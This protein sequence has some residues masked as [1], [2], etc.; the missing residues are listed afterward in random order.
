M[1]GKE[2]GG[3]KKVIHRMEFNPPH[4][5]DDEHDE[6]KEEERYRGKE[7]D[8]SGQWSRLQLLRHDHG[9]LIPRQQ[10]LVGPTQVPTASGLGFGGWGNLILG[11]VYVLEVGLHVQGEVLHLGY[12]VAAKAVAPF[13]QSLRVVADLQRRSLT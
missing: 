2:G 1:E 9:D 6:E 10:I 5:S 3:E 4:R 12:V 11:K 7:T 13:V 8:L